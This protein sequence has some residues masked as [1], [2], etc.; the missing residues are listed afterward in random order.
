ME[1]EQMSQALRQSRQ[2]GLVILV[3]V[4]VGLGYA[5]WAAAQGGDGAM[6]AFIQ[7]MHQ[8]NP[9]EVL[10]AFSRQSPWRYVNYEIGT[11]KVR[12][13]RMVTFQQM[14]ADFQHKTGWYRFFLDEPD[15]YT[16]MVNF[17]HGTPWGKRGAYTFVPPEVGTSRTHITWRHEG[18]R[19]AIGEIGETT[20]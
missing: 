4:V 1:K 17:I 20:P 12:S 9:Q 6:G 13:S 19:C 3:L 18:G 8:K 11:G 7:A 10:A 2:A 16:F 15:G 14:A 5:G